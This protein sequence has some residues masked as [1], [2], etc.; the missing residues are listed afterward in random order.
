MIEGPKFEKK[1]SAEQAY[2]IEKSDPEMRIA[3]FVLDPQE[4][5]NQFHD[6]LQTEHPDGIEHG[7]FAISEIYE[8]EKE[9]LR[10]N[11]TELHP[12]LEVFLSAT[13][14]YDPVSIEILFTWLKEAG[15]TKDQVGMW[16]DLES[17]GF[18]SLPQQRQERSMRMVLNEV[19]K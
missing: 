14:E 3:K 5:I 6:H 11:Y 7:I 19:F 17:N 1:D 16:V 18:T 13:S 2:N 10:A 15:F 9:I 8:L 4:Y 12:D